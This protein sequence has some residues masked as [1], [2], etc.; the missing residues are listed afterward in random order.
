[1]VCWG[2]L[3]LILCILELS[4]NSGLIFLVKSKV[5]QNI[6]AFLLLEGVRSLYLHAILRS[7]LLVVV[8]GVVVAVV[9]CYKTISHECLW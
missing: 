3:I 8:V 7:L 2:R 1:M 9:C 4:K 6:S 5:W